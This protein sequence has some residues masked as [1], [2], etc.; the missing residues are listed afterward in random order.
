MRRVEAQDDILASSTPPLIA[1][2]SGEIYDALKW[3]E[4]LDGGSARFAE[5][6]AAGAVASQDGPVGIAVERNAGD[7]KAIRCVGFPSLSMPRGRNLAWSNNMTLGAA[8][9]G[10]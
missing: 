4:A 1:A 5:W 3:C 9:E 10:K 7:A 6:N 8:G 2:N